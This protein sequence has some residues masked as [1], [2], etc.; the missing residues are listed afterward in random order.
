MRR[1]VFL[2]KFIDHIDNF[3]RCPGARR[4]SSRWRRAAGLPMS[5]A[6]RSSAMHW[7]GAPSVG[8]QPTDHRLTPIAGLANAST[9]RA[10]PRSRP[11][12]EVENEDEK[13]FTG[14]NRARRFPARPSTRSSSG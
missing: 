12:V 9:P 10:P 13:D 3:K 2:H 8:R 7:C 5:P 14:Q 1:S 6:V 11:G 4:R